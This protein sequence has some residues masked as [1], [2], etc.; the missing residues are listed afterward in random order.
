M[1][2]FLQQLIFNAKNGGWRR[3]RRSLLESIAALGF[4]IAL[5]QTFKHGRALYVAMILALGPHIVQIGIGVI[6]VGFGIG[7]HWFRRLN[8]R[9]Y[10]MVEVVFGAV[11]GFTI[12]F[13][14]IPSRPAPSQWA[15]LV[16]CAY[17]V[18]RG[19][20]NMS[21]AK[22]KLNTRTSAASRK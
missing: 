4:G 8:Q 3:A 11:S 17:V 18:A 22:A 9:W 12:A 20:N 10:G 21:D 5:A 1:K 6:V 14:M 7:A 16:G 2:S 13:S 15:S 19:L